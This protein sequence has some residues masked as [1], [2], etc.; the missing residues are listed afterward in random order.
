MARLGALLAC[1]ALLTCLQSGAEARRPPKYPDAYEVRMM[2]WR[3]RLV[4]MFCGEPFGL[5]AC[6]RSKPGNTAACAGLRSPTPTR[7]RTPTPPAP[8]PA[9]ASGTPCTGSSSDYHT[10]T[11]M[12]VHYVTLHVGFQFQI[13]K[14]AYMLSDNDSSPP[15]H[16][17]YP[18]RF[19]LDGPGRRVRMD[20]YAGSNVIL[21]KNVRAVQGSLESVQW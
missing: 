4:S 10:F 1:L 5:L 8:R 12:H 13:C 20:T 9:A 16:R 7:C 19:W 6:S 15:V 21:A 11:Q 2:R 3:H 14:H 17:S 18:V